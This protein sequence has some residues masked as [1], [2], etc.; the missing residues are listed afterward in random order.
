MR[1]EMKKNCI[2]IMTDA[3]FDDLGAI[4]PSATLALPGKLLMSEIDLYKARLQG[5]F[6]RFFEEAF[7]WEEMTWILYPYF[8]GRK[9]H[10]YRRVDYEDSD[11]EFEKFVQSGFARANVPIRPGFEGA[12]EHYLATGKVWNGGALPGISSDLFLPLSMEIQESLG[13]K[14]EQPV[15]YGEPWLVKVP[16]NLVKLRHD[17]NVPAWKKDTVTGDWV[18]AEDT[19]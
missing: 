14:S 16:T 18:E 11:P 12:L 10:W 17:D 6:V 8:W 13:K 9:D 4:Q 19:A 7:E 2:S 1:N 5:P 3:H 15:K